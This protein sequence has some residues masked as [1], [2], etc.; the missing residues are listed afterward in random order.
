MYDYKNIKNI[1]MKFDIMQI[2]I[3]IVNTLILIKSY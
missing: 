2:Y 3:Y 1:K